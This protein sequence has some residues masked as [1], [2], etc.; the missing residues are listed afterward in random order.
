MAQMKLN[1]VT[2]EGSV[3][4]DQAKM[5]TVRTIDGDRGIMPHHE[6]LITGVDIGPIKIKE[7][8][9]ELHLAASH[10]YMEVTPE[11]VTILVDTAE[12]AD[13]IDVERAEEAK[14]R[15]EDRLNKGNDNINE[16]RAEIAL[17]KAI[18]RLRV[19]KGR[20]FE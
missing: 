1:I 14:K 3:Y 20:N 13:E 9:D 18:N 11:E 12:F 10:G 4:D 7:D 5:I 17:Q 6:P 8:S 19:T 16:R 2:P 15:A